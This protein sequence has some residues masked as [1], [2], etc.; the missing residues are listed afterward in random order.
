MGPDLLGVLNP[1]IL[2]QLLEY[3]PCCRTVQNINF[4]IIFKIKFSANEGY[5]HHPHYIPKL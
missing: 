5:H 1:Y 3:P 4:K 2:G